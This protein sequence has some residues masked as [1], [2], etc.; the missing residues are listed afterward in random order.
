MTRGTRP[1]IAR[2]LAWLLG[3]ANA[4]PPLGCRREFYALKERL[5][6]RWGRVVG[7][8]VQHL[9]DE[10]YGWGFNGCT[11]NRYCKCDGSGVFR[12]RWVLLVR[13][14]MG[15]RIFHSRP[16]PFVSTPRPMATIRGRI[17]H[18][19]VSAHAATEAQLWLALV[20]DRPLFWRILRMSRYCGWQWR[21]MLVLQTVVFE[22]R[23]IAHSALR[24]LRTRGGDAIP[25]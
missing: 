19:R 7:V 15:G 21:P 22:L 16:R 23:M 3:L 9:I 5:L 13:C 1:A 12:E 4:H 20:F 25:F 11:Y 6:A 14:E 24:W 2:P 8:D 10:C 17:L 18:R